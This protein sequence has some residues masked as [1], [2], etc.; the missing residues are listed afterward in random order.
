MVTHVKSKTVNGTDIDKLHELLDKLRQE[1][2][3][4]RSQFRDKHRWLGRAHGRSE[5]KGFYAAGAEDDRRSKPYVLDNDE[6]PQLLG[7]DKGANPVEFLLHALAGCVSTTLVYHAAAR[8]IEIES[9]ETSI[10]GDI[11]V[12]GFTGISNEVPRGYQKIRVKMRV[13][14]DTD[15]DA[16]KL[17]ELAKY[18]PVYNTIINP[19]PVELTVEKV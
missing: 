7:E 2:S 5:I 11:D 15:V 17:A 19:T 3:L 1:P 8:G 14:S 12:R 16:E 10:E 4:G 6:P 18:S 9:L 13:K